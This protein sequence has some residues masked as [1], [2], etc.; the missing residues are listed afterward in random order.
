ME[1]T[2]PS[3]S[4]RTRRK[5]GGSFCYNLYLCPTTNLLPSRYLH[6]MKMLDI[7]Q[8]KS[9]GWMAKIRKDLYQSIV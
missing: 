9:P 3:A 5:E 8:S 1:F 2:L 6:H 7:L 4:V